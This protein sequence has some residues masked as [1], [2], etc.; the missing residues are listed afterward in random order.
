MHGIEIQAKAA[1]RATYRLKGKAWIHTVTQLEKFFGK[2]SFNA[3]SYIHVFE[4]LNNPA[5]VFDEL[6]NVVRNEGKLLIV[7]PN[8]E[9]WQFKLFKS[10]WFHLD[11]PRHLNFYTFELINKEMLDRGFKL[12]KFKNFDFEQGPFGFIQSFFNMFTLKKDIFFESLKGNKPKGIKN[13]NFKLLVMKILLVL[14]F[15]IAFIFELLASVFHQGATL[16][17]IY[18]K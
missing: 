11:Y 1:L 9:S 15:P 18:S 5:E 12:V 17:L 14:L 7:I 3:V 16:E 8:I 4:H 13:L 2:N 6:K 10:N